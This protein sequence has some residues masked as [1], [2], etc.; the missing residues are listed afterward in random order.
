MARLSRQADSNQN[1]IPER[2]GKRSGSAL[3]EVKIVQAG[4]VE[5]RLAVRGASFRRFASSPLQSAGVAGG[6][7]GGQQHGQRRLVDRKMH[8]SK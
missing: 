2:S 5:P 1:T 6:S 3:L 8:N 4:E 7:Y